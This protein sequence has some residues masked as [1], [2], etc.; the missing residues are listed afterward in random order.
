MKTRQISKNKVLINKNGMKAYGSSF[1]NYLKFLFS[2]NI[3]RK[4]DIDI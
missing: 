3:I 4:Q 1:I 2:F